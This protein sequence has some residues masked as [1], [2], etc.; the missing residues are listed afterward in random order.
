M[1]ELE[2]RTDVKFS[3]K[4]N[5]NY[6]KD[7]EDV[8][9]FNDNYD[10]ECWEFRTNISDVCMFIDEI[11]ENWYGIFEPR[12]YYANDIDYMALGYS[13]LDSL[14]KNLKDD[15]ETLGEKFVNDPNSLT[16]AERERL[17][18][19]CSKSIAR[20]KRMHDWVISTDTK[21]PSNSE[22]ETPI[23]I[24]DETFSA[25]TA[26]YRIAKF[27]SE[28]ETYFDKDYAL[29]YY[30]YTFVALMVDQRAKNMFLTYWGD[31]GKW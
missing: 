29:I 31:T 23:R 10:V 13:S 25:D 30:V 9:A 26:E 5:F 16:A 20:F 11:P 12:C 22:F 28:F 18:L 17:K 15:I 4:G 14:H 8:F 2:G 6:D 1:N 27:K 24:G 7:A 19:L 3:S 21:H